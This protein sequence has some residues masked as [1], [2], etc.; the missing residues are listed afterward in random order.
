[1]LANEGHFD[2]RLVKKFALSLPVGRLR[3]LNVSVSRRSTRGSDRRRSSS[4]GSLR[5][6]DEGLVY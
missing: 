6:E 4:I 1:M 5:R 3:L 2:R